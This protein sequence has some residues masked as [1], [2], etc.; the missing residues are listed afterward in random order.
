MSTISS[1][2]RLCLSTALAVASAVVVALPASARPDPGPT[3]DRQTST[4]TT[5]TTA[6]EDEGRCPLRRVGTQYVRCDN[7]TGNGVA[8]PAWVLER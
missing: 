6:P 8:A 1:G 2:R 5:S 7:L 4:A 3:L